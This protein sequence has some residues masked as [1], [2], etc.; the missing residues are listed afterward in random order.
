MSGCPLGF[1]TDDNYGTCTLC[2]PNLNCAT[3]SITTNSTIICLSCKYQFFLQANGTCLRSCDYGLFQ[4]TWNRTCDLCSL[5]CGNCTSPTSDACSDCRSG[6]VFLGNSTGRY[7]LNSCP[8]NYYY[9]SG[10]NCLNCYTTCLT[11]NGS[12]SDNCL[13]CITGLYL[14]N[15]MCRYV[16]PANYYP[17]STTGRCERCDLNCNFCFG[18]TVDNC[19]ACVSGFVLNNFTCTTSCP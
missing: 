11:C 2:D 14:S 5:M 16:C 3:C 12:N 10:T 15:G 1:Y 17:R 6:K 9:Q 13:T 4:N 18:P 19:T 8:V 7:C